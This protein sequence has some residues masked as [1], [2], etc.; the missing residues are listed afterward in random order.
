MRLLNKLRNF[1]PTL[2]LLLQ[3]FV[4]KKRSDFFVAPLSGSS[5]SIAFRV[6]IS[7][8]MSDFET[9]PVPY[10]FQNSHLMRPNL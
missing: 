5:A 8:Q 6:A 4:A 3:I 7:C 2:I 10:H 9:K 1:F